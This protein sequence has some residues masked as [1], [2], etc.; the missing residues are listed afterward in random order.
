MI[1]LCLIIHTLKQGL[2]RLI[3]RTAITRLYRDFTCLK[4][5]NISHKPAFSNT[6]SELRIFNEEA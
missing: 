5:T 6:L 2:A 3:F 1:A 4:C